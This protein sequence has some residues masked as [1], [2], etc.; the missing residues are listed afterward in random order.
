M[1][2]TAEVKISINMDNRIRLMRFDWF[3]FRAQHKQ[4]VDD[5]R[6]PGF[7]I[8]LEQPVKDVGNEQGAESQQ[9]PCSQFSL[10]SIHKPPR[11][12]W[13]RIEMVLP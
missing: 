7:I 4:A 1:L 12:V 10:N 2:G 13:M 6:I 9:D 3:Y 8:L 11:S 5:L